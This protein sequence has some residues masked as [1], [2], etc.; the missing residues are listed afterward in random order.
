MLF[1]LNALVLRA[2][3]EGGDTNEAWWAE[4]LRI[5]ALLLLGAA[6]A[7]DPQAGSARGGQ[8][9]KLM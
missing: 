8:G 2:P 5:Q 7:P 4:T 3:V 6:G 9:H 1:S